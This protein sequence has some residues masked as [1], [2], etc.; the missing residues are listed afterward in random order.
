MFGFVHLSLLFA[1]LVAA[2][3]ASGQFATVWQLGSDDGRSLPFSQESFSSN[4]LPGSA[5]LKDDDYYFAGTYPA[6]VGV[7][8]VDET[9]S[10]F[11]R[12]VS[13]DDL[14]NRIHFPL[15]AAQVSAT[16]LLRVS[17]DLI[18]GGTWVNGSIPGFGTHHI[19][20]RFNGISLGIFN[21]ITWNRTLVFTCLHLQ[22]Q[23]WPG[24]THC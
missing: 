5:S 6:P 13:S 12:A 3:G 22:W 16:S 10:L 2:T 1:V 24:L 15:T 7:V 21:I 19:S 20:V 8:A 23:R 9:T 17:V 11:E 14:R 4:N 18:D